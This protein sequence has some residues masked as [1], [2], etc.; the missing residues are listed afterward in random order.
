M[1]EIWSAEN[2][3]RVLRT[4]HAVAMCTSKVCCTVRRAIYSRVDSS[5]MLMLTQQCAREWLAGYVA[6]GVRATRSAKHVAVAAAGDTTERGDDDSVEEDRQAT[7]ADNCDLRLQRCNVWKL[8]ESDPHTRR[9]ENG[10]CFVPYSMRAWE[11][12]PRPEREKQRGKLNVFCGWHVLP[13]SN[14]GLC[15]LILRHIR[16]VWCSNDPT[17]YE[18]VIQYFAHAV[19]RPFELPRVAMVVVGEPGCGKTCVMACMA[20]LFGEHGFQLA[21]S[22]HLF[23]RF[24]DVTAHRVWL[25]ADEMRWKGDGKQSDLIGLLKALITDALLCCESK[26]GAKFQIENCIRLVMTSNEDFAVPAR[27]EERRYFV[28]RAGDVRPRPYM[29]ALARA[30][31]TPEGI[32]A[33]LHHLLAVDLSGFH[34][35]EVPRSAEYLAQVRTSSCVL[36]FVSVYVLT[37]RAG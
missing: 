5:P 30:L 8:F 13:R 1:A 21:N 17:L 10:V 15:Q 34:V 18:Y 19:Q 26:Y 31:T 7:D 16:E 4:T 28:L 2:M 32:S 14:D 27:V 35:T 25:V 22:E 29:D 37:T 24:N 3:T 20:H 11:P 33:L 6:Y 23:G 9:Y 36:G 12:L